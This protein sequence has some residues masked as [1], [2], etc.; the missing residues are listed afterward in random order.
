MKY[1]LLVAGL[2]SFTQCQTQQYDLERIGKIAARGTASELSAVL[3]EEGFDNFSETLYGEGSTALIHI[4]AKNQ[5][6]PEVLT[7]LI[8]RGADIE[9]KDYRNRNAISVAIDNDIAEGVEILFY[10]GADYQNTIL[11]G[12]S[13]LE[14]CRFYE[15]KQRSVPSACRKLIDL[16]K[17]RKD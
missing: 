15:I 2:L 5:R 4:A 11:Y 13:P 3:D 16:H 8:E 9:V 17:A 1:V 12:K 7:V 10:A 6:H 14:V